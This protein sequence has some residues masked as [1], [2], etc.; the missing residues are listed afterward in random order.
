MDKEFRVYNGGAGAIMSEQWEILEQWGD[1]ATSAEILEWAHESALYA[2]E[3][4]DRT[5]A[6]YKAALAFAK[7]QLGE[8]AEICRF[9]SWGGVSASTLSD[10][11]GVERA[12]STFDISGVTNT[13]YNQLSTFSVKVDSFGECQLVSWLS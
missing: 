13:K 3:A 1:P 8:K 2:N 7:T 5:K 10:C 12:F 6:H 4:Y 9:F 11:A